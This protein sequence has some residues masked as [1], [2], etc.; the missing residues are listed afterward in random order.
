MMEERV[1][2]GVELISFCLQHPFCSVAP[3]PPGHA[4]PGAQAALL[5]NP[6]VSFCASGIGQANLDSWD[7]WTGGIYRPL[8]RLGWWEVVEGQGQSCPQGIY[9]KVSVKAKE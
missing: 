2:P 9:S 4:L 1:E 7:P 6:T 3:S 8:M 5:R